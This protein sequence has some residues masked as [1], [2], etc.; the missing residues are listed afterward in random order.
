MNKSIWSIINV[1][2]QAIIP[3]MVLLYVTPIFDIDG[4]GR[5]SYVESTIRLFTILSLLGLNIYGLREIGKVSINQTAKIQIF[6]ELLF[7]HLISTIIGITA[8]LIL[9]FTLSTFK[10]DQTLHLIGCLSVL[11][12]V[13]IMEWYFQGIGKFKWIAIRSIISRIFYIALVVVLVSEKNHQTR[14]ITILTLTTLVNAIFSFQYLKKNISFRV[15]KL[16]RLKQHI[17]PIFYLFLTS[18]AISVYTSLDT[19]ILRLLTDEENTGMYTIVIKIFR[20]PILFFTAI[21]FV[22]IPQVSYYLEKKNTQFIDFFITKVFYIYLTISLFATIFIYFNSESIVLIFAG[23]NL[24]E[25][26]ALLRTL[27]FGIPF[28]ALSNISGLIILIPFGDEKWFSKIMLSISLLNIIISPLFVVALK[29]KGIVYAILITEIFV[30]LFTFLR[31]RKIIK[32]RLGGSK[33]LQIFL[34]SIALILFSISI[35][36]R[37]LDTDFNILLEILFCIILMWYLTKRDVIDKKIIKL[38]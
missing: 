5:I 6:N 20:I 35:R 28:I 11:F 8:Y 1:A 15:I 27:I 18:A 25:I 19:V 16:N 12:N 29:V 24:E 3:L 32:F 2:S 30:F 31:S 9:I 17:K 14:Y 7:I 34:C 33:I 23:E 38:L 21:N 26:S 36:V 22:I 37:P 13:F 10:N 4:L